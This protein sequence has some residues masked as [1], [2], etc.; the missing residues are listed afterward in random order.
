MGS[1][2]SPGLKALSFFFISFFLTT[3]FL[4][5]ASTA[6]AQNMKYLEGVVRDGKTGAF[7]ANAAVEIPSMG[8]RV[9]TDSEGNYAF[10]R[11]WSGKPWDKGEGILSQGT[12]Y[13]RVSA[14]GYL[15]REGFIELSGDSDGATIEFQL[16]SISTAKA[17]GAVVAVNSSGVDYAFVPYKPDGEAFYLKVPAGVVPAGKT[18]DFCCA[19]NPGPFTLKSSNLVHDTREFHHGTY[20]PVILFADD[21]GTL[22]HDFNKYL[23]VGFGKKIIPGYTNP[24]ARGDAWWSSE[25]WNKL[26]RNRIFPGWWNLGLACETD[27]FS[28]WL[29]GFSDAAR[30]VLEKSVHGP[31]GDWL[32]T[33]IWFC[34]EPGYGHI[35]Y[36][37]DVVNGYIIAGITDTLSSSYEGRFF[38]MKDLKDSIKVAA[39]GEIDLDFGVESGKAWV[40]SSGSSTA[41]IRNGSEIWKKS[42]ASRKVN[43]AQGFTGDPNQNGEIQVIEHGYWEWFRVKIFKDHYLISETETC[44]VFD[45]TGIAIRFV[46]ST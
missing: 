13:V 30:P 41:E 10:W 25:G 1:I 36:S 40:N 20:L 29:F 19:E 27:H 11:N 39:G 44:P 24:S 2:S 46:P 3:T 6:T 32:W 37:I 22:V 31:N 21:Q 5:T 43:I 38:D 4:F 15:D 8:L 28:Y 9:T 33:E 26:E 42:S 12:Y 35:L 7:L 18:W 14:P 45:L 16:T 17:N 34:C 23:R